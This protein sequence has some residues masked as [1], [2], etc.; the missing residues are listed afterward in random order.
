LHDLDDRLRESIPRAP[1]DLDRE[2]AGKFE[3]A[4]LRGDEGGGGRVHVDAPAGSCSGDDFD[5]MRARFQRC[6]L[7]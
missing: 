1:H 4:G 6:N 2:R 7:S 3:C 5:N